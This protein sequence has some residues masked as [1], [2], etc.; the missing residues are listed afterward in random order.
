MQEGPVLR[1][2]SRKKAITREEAF[3]LWK[4]GKVVGLFNLPSK[5]VFD[6][7]QDFCVE[8]ECKPNFF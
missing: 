7:C 2:V 8:S 6:A 4:E 5:E 3:E 1:V